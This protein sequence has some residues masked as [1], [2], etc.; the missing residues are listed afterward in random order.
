MSSKQLLIIILVASFSLTFII[1]AIV[2]VYKYDPAM[3][4]YESEKKDTIPIDTIVFEPTILVSEKKL[5]QLE[6]GLV[7]KANIKAQKDAIYNE[8]MKLLD[9]I[10]RVYGFI[11]YYKDSIAKVNKNLGASGSTVQ[12]LQDS[13]LKVYAQLQDALAKNK[14]A[15]K[16]IEDQENFL[17]KKVDT[18][19]SK[20]FEDFAKLYNNANP[21][22]VAKILEQI[23]ERDAAKILKL[24][25]KK[26][27]GKIIESMLPERAAA[28][29]LLGAG[30]K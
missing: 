25:Q 3:L 19:E 17:S 28:I 2:G 4:G 12:F 5:S 27:A 15:Q 16:R 29:L 24:M 7:E 26:K 20:N 22:D 18:L 10:K 21:K 1:I 30:E 11:S 9:S 23:D 6:Y 8:K 14:N 13:L